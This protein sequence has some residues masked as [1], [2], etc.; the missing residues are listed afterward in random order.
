MKVIDYKTG[1]V[2]NNSINSQQGYNLPQF[3]A[4]KNTFNQPQA[5]NSMNKILPSNNF[6]KPNVK[7]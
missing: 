3:N 1:L 5:L 2:N 7:H 6:I 4:N